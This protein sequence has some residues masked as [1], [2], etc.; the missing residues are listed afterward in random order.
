MVEKSEKNLNAKINICKADSGY[1]SGDNIAKIS[2]NQM[3]A[4]IDDPGEPPDWPGQ[5]KRM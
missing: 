1:H 2:G 5:V 4:L 3:E